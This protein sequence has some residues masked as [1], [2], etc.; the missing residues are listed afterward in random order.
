MSHGTVEQP[1]PLSI[2]S[3]GPVEAQ[4]GL[5]A[6]TL[7][8]YLAEITQRYAEREAVVFHETDGTVSRWTYAELYRRAQ[9]VACALV[10]SGQPKGGFVAVLMTNRPE[11]LASV[12]GILL[13]GGTAVPLST[14]STAE[15]LAYLIKTSCASTLI[16][17]AGVLKKDFARVIAE[18]EPA[19]AT[20]QPAQLRS[21]RFP[22]LR[23]LVAVRGSE[24]GAIETWEG[25][26]TS[27]EGIDHALVEARATAV[28]P[29][30]PALLY[31]SSGST[32]RP[33][34]I[35]NSQRGVAIQFWRWAYQLGLP[36]DGTVRGWGA[37]GF[38]W[39]GA[40]A[41]AAGATFSCGGSLVLQRTF[42]AEIAL[43]L[44]QKE[45]VNY[46]TCWPHQY[47]QF[48][49]VPNYADA[50]LS[51]LKYI[52]RGTAIE[53]HPSIDT[54]WVE[55]T[56]SYGSTETF[57]FNCG[58]A[59][60]VP[61]VEWNN[62]H[63]RPFPGNT[64]KVVD[65]FSGAILPVGERGE[66]AVKGATLML[67]YIGVP[68]DETLDDEGFFRTG[69]GGYFDEEGR[70]Y[71]EGRLNDI[72]KTGGANVS[73]LEIDAMLSSAPGVKM[74]QTVG[75][76][77]AD[78]GEMIVSCVVPTDDSSLDETLLREQL[79][80]RLASYKVPRR[81]LGVTEQELSFTGSAK[82]RTAALRELAAQKLFASQQSS[83]EN[84]A[85]T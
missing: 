41:Q 45:R 25:F 23:R 61:Q 39:S 70:L 53:S 69:D 11:W 50:D 37:N 12:F 19:T 38:F 59:N 24:N 78:L 46:L 80:L 32:G 57:T 85:S 76:P 65:P 52:T 28:K 60:S 18:L 62:C 7:P 17:E 73:P 64:V 72:I 55:P 22:F 56:C 49:E 16:F 10:A 35:L 79:K 13:A 30:D 34:A 15:E 8:G 47:S 2:F 48:P 82:V 51:S 54:D 43:G 31:F 67:G 26:L 44:F 71:F 77:H 20:S 29:S 33:K 63:G 9:Q 66:I 74:S 5:G 68:A 36:S 40:F 4:P 14:F 84:M 58:I 3:G 83:S 1:R 42:D 75:V 81:I 27:G 21:T 6:L